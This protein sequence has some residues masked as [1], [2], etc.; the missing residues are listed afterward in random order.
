MFTPRI[1]PRSESKQQQTQPMKINVLQVALCWGLCSCA[2]GMA[3]DGE[4]LQTLVPVDFAASSTDAPTRGEEIVGA[5]G[6]AAEGGFEAWTYF[7]EGTWTGAAQAELLVA[8]AASVRGGALDHAHVVSHDGGVSWSYG[9]APVYWP[10]RRSVSSFAIAPADAAGVTV[11]HPATDPVPRVDFTLPSPGRERADLLFARAVTDLTRGGSGGMIAERFSHA[12]SQVAICAFKEP[13]LADSEVF[14]TSVRLTGICESGTARLTT[15][16]VWS[17]TGAAATLEFTSSN[18]L[19]VGEPIAATSIDRAD[20]LLSAAVGKLFV[21]PQTLAGDQLEIVYTIDGKEVVKTMPIPMPDGEQAW[22]PGRSYSITLGIRE[23]NDIIVGAGWTFHESDPSFSIPESGYYY[24][25]A[26]GGDGADGGNATAARSRGGSGS[27]NS[28][29]YYFDAG[30]TLRVQV[31]ERGGDVTTDASCGAGGMAVAAGGSIAAWF[32]GGGNG[33]NGGE[34]NNHVGGCG[35]GG[36]AASGILTGG[37]VHL[38]AAG[39]GGGGGTRGYSHVAE[40]AGGGNSCGGGNGVPAGNGTLTGG[41]NAKTTPQGGGLGTAQVGGKGVA[42]G[43]TRYGSWPGGGGGGGGGGYNESRRGGGRGGQGSLGY[44]SG[45]GG[46]GGT[47][48]AGGAYHKADGSPDVPSAVWQA[49]ATITPLP[50]TSTGNG[51]VRITPIG[52]RRTRV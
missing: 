20:A 37:N 28:A 36:G 23:S 2:P 8:N 29:L 18:S 14:V 15:P 45:A 33:G 49:V 13:S 27:F 12:L 31:G 52:R 11:T 34:Q 46:A 38:A 51:V 40:M 6:L 21:L 30:E 7:Y 10:E 5:S 24:V 3:G 22:E 50:R 39:G 47:N 9:T 32:G 41:D 25:E 4:G 17:A 26:W 35:G 43:N 16:V 19:L 42:G 44:G 48:W 1:A